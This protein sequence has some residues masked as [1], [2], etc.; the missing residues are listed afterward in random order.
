MRAWMPWSD[1]LSNTTPFGLPV[2]WLDLTP[3]ERSEILKHQIATWEWWRRVKN[4]NKTL[5]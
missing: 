3:A 4:K 5:K 2:D 1:N